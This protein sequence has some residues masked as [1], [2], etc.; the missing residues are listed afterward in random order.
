MKKG[1]TM[2]TPEI[3]YANAD[4]VA[5]IVAGKERVV[6][7]GVLEAAA[8]QEDPALARPYSYILA[9]ARKRWES[10]QAM[11]QEQREARERR[12]EYLSKPNDEN[13]GSNIDPTPG[14]K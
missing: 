3:L 1:H 12:D 6:S 5:F 7:W 4:A 8:A 9:M 13:R 2:N 11:L 14:S 10:A